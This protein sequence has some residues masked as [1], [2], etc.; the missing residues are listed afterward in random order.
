MSK[1]KSSTVRAKRADLVETAGEGDQP[2]A[3]HA[4]VGRLQ[5][6]DAAQARPGSGR[7]RRYRCRW[8]AGPCRRPRRPPRRRWSRR[9]SAQGPTDCAWEKG[10]VLVRSAH[11]ELVHVRFAD[12]HGIG[13][14]QPGDHRGVVRRA[15]VLQH[16]RGAGRRFALRAEHV[17]DGHGQA[18]QSADGLPGGAAAI[19]F[20]CSGERRL[21]IHSQKCLDAAV[22]A[23]DLI[24]IRPRQFDDVIAR[25]QSARSG[26]RSVEKFSRAVRSELAKGVAFTVQH[27]LRKSGDVPPVRPTARREPDNIPRPGAARWPGPARDRDSARTTSSRKTLAKSRAWAIGSTPVVSTSPSKSM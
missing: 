9:E 7:N 20:L 2:E 16:P 12:Q 17:L 13:R 18:A 25:C 3:A 15:E 23:F 1:A 14:L 6:G 11:R 4:A 26:G 22:V 27:A 24:E 5:P 21:G 8:K 19:D 10:R